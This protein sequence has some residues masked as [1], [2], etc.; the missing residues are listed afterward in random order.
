MGALKLVALDDVVAFPGMPLVL[1]ADVAGDTR[2]FLVPRQGS[3]YARVGVVA[4]EPE[5]LD[6]PEACRD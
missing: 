3:G 1:Q 6:E 2:A 5:L 4:E